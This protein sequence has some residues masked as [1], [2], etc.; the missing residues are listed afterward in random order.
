MKSFG[1]LILLLLIALSPIVTQAEE[2]SFTEAIMRSTFRISGPNSQGTAFILGKSDPT[3]K[4][5]SFIY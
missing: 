4:D 3:N 5:R 1:A 2:S